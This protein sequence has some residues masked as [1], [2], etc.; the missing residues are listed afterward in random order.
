MFRKKTSRQ[1]DGKLAY[2][3]VF[4]EHIS[5]TLKMEAI[6][7]SEMSVEIQRDYTASYPRK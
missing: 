3:L 7:S 5:S 1:A 6:C 2:L 4:S